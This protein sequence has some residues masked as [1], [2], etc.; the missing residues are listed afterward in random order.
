MKRSSLQRKPPPRVRSPLIGMRTEP[1]GV[2]TQSGADVVAVPKD[3][4]AKPGKR[5]PTA[6]EARWMD[7][8]VRYGCIACR[9]D[10]HEPRPTAVHH[11]LRGGVRIGH[12]H[13]LPLCDTP[14]GG[15]H[16]N[17]AAIGLVSRHPWKVR[18]E[19]R[20]GSEDSLLHKLRSALN[21]S[22]TNG[23]KG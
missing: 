21:W 16:Q 10:G 7:A 14:D 13:T 15:H 9:I 2:M 8:I 17:G 12:L 1:R 11:I 3:A 19:Q 23:L 20:Y 5:A 4:R 18:F 22:N 6:D